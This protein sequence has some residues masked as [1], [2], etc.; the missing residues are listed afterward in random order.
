MISYPCEVYAH[1]DIKAHGHGL[2]LIDRCLMNTDLYIF[3][4]DFIP[5]F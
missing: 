1:A 5:Y 4:S 3:L 2:F